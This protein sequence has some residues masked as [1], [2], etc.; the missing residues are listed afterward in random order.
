[1]FKKFN[2]NFYDSLFALLPLSI[3]LGPAV[4]LINILLFIL[5][6]F[7]KYFKKDHLNY[8]IKDK[9]IILFFLLNLYLIF[10]TLISIEPSSGI[11]RN[12]G[13]VRFIFLFIAINYFFYI[14]K[15]D[16]SS[17][18]IWTIV[19]LVVVFDVYFERFYGTNILGFGSEEQDFGRRVISFFK[20]EPIAGAYLSGLLF[21]V[22]GYIFT[23]FKNKKRT[24]KII[25]SFLLLIFLTSVLITGERSNTIR[26]FVGFLLFVFLLDYFKL[27]YKIIFSASFVVIFFISLYQSEYLKE[28]YV[29][30]IY[31]LFFT[32]EI[33]AQHDLKNNQYIKLYKS[34]LSVFK[35]NP[36][37]G[38]GNKN[39]RVETCHKDKHDKFNYYCTTHPHQIY[40]E[41]LSEHG[42]VGTIISLSVFFII[43]FKV[44]RQIIESKNYIQIGAF[45]YILSNFLPMIPSGAFFSDFNITFFMLNL[46]LMYAVSDKTNIFK[47]KINSGPLAQ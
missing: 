1:M 45:T 37:F 13:F 16:L 15:Y 2:I 6:Y 4:S 44:L 31:N 26:V 46:S 17:F 30:Q 34:G 41:F 27:R 8:F 10:N 18:K 40:I 29:E 38:V 36:V 32:S 3:I 5:I 33:K 43:I 9:T 7:F 25:P 12:F 11:F 39:Y 20:D 14:K 23:I 42:I 47:D 35:K 21:I 22:A 28:R 19:F 24:F